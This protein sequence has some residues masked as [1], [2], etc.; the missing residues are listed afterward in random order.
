MYYLYIYLGATCDIGMLSGQNLIMHQRF[1]HSHISERERL[2]SEAA[3]WEYAES[4]FD[5]ANQPCIVN[6]KVFQSCLLNLVLY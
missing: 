4:F 5:D 6:Q 1:D 3:I 2:L